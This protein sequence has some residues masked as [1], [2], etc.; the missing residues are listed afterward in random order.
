M[1]KP[2]EP[3]KKQKSEAG[4]DDAAADKKSKEEKEKQRLNNLL[5][6][7]IFPS[8]ARIVQPVKNTQVKGGTI[9]QYEEG[10]RQIFSIE[11]IKKE[12]THRMTATAES[13]NGGRIFTLENRETGNIT[14]RVIEN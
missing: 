14:W 12:N 3:T 10:E 6:K 9:K 11:G 7:G 8:S 5:K 1:L 4:A 2:E 13:L